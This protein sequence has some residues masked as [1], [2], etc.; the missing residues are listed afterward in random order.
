[1]TSRFQDGQFYL[2]KTRQPTVVTAWTSSL[3]SKEMLVHEMRIA[4]TMMQGTI[5]AFTARY[6][7]IS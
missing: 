6:S 1:M 3:S 7:I 2:V 4:V 5:L